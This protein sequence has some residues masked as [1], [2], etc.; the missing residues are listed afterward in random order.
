MTRA[1]E[2]ARKEMGGRTLV[3]WVRVWDKQS[4][5]LAKKAKAKKK[6]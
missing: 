1:A 6:T 4:K 2:R 5:A 3:E